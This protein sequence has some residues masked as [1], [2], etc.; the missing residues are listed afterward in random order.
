MQRSQWKL[1]LYWTLDFHFALIMRVKPNPGSFV[2]LNN[3]QF[4]EKYATWGESWLICYFTPL[5]FPNLPL[6]LYIISITLTPPELFFCLHL[7]MVFCLWI[8]FFSPKWQKKKKFIKRLSLCLVNILPRTCCLR[9]LAFPKNTE[10]FW[11]GVL[12]FLRF[13]DLI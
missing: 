1:S 12:L 3:S 5:F 11:E 6:N 4:R 8:H 2:N 10:A 9:L 13:L 7:F